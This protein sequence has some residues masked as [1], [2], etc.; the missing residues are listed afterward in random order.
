MTTM[1]EV[2]GGVAE[3]DVARVASDARQA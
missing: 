2:A 3:T 1:P